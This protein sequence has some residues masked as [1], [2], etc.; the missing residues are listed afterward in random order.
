MVSSTS[1]QTPISEAARN[2][3]A[4]RDG[5]S[6]EGRFHGSLISPKPTPHFRGFSSFQNQRYADKIK[7]TVRILAKLRKDIKRECRTDLVKTITEGSVQSPCIISNADTKNKMRRI[8]CLRQAD[9]VWRLDVVM[10][11]LFRGRRPVDLW[12]LRNAKNVFRFTKGIP[13][14]STDG[15]RL[16]K[17]KDCQHPALCI[18]PYHIVLHVKELEVYLVNFI[19]NTRKVSSTSTS[20]KIVFLPL[21]VEVAPPN[22]IPSVFSTSDLQQMATSRFFGLLGRENANFIFVSR[23]ASISDGGSTKEIL[24]ADYLG[25]MLKMETDDYAD[26]QPISTNQQPDLLKMCRSR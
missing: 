16:S 13:L 22:I 17:C 21:F 14:E 7:W 2:T 18:N 1:C 8:D 12:T 15:E 25:S 10:V 6:D 23:L 11:V 19:N 20:G 3:H 24:G 4:D 5:A 26:A 9:K